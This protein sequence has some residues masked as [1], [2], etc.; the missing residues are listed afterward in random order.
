MISNKCL[1]ISKF[2]I[3]YLQILI[4]FQYKY[5]N[6]LKPLG[7]TESITYKPDLPLKLVY[8]F[9]I[10]NNFVEYGVSFS[11]DVHKIQNAFSFRSKYNILFKIC[12]WSVVNF[13]SYYI[14]KVINL[15]PLLLLIILLQAFQK[16]KKQQ[17]QLF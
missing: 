13:F 1:I 11:T 3:N 14:V 4:N 12:S 8:L 9:C 5:K 10:I 7:S 6:W 17:Q 15:S 16:S 2:T